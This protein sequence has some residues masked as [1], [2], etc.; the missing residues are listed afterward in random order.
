MCPAVYAEPGVSAGSA[1][2]IEADT[3]RVLYE[4]NAHDRRSMAS[5]TKI[6]TAMLV[7]E[8]EELDRVVEIT[9]EM[10]QVEGSS[11]DCRPGTR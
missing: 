7:L 5:T 11:M 2:L 1:I 9:Q 10:D 3:G 6:M 8:S 4:K